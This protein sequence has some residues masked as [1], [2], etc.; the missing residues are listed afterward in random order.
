MAKKAQK[1][2][3]IEPVTGLTGAQW[4]KLQRFCEQ[5]QVPP[6]VNAANKAIRE[7][8]KFSKGRII[9]DAV[10]Q[11]CVKYCCPHLTGESAQ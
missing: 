1:A 8:F 4:M 10:I 5:H 2:K 9:D 6:N 11:H 7:C 3:P